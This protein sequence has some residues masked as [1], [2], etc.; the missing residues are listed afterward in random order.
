M[1]NTIEDI[2]SKKLEVQVIPKLREFNSISLDPGDTLVAF[3][4]KNHYTIDEVQ[5][6]YE[7]LYKAFP[8][9]NILCIEKHINLGVIKEDDK[10]IKTLL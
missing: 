2:D 1:I 5:N 10:R 9:N 8:N 7:L 6:I 3:Y 4:D